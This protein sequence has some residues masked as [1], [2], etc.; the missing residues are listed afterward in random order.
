MLILADELQYNGHFE[1]FLFIL[2]ITIFMG[3]VICKSKT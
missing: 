3:M 2:E 1:Y